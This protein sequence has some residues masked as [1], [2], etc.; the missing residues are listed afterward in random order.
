MVQNPPALEDKPMY[1]LEFSDLK[2]L[3]FRGNEERL[4]LGLVNLNSL[5][6]FYTIF[7]IK[8][9]NK[10]VIADYNFTAQVKING[11]Y[12]KIATISSIS[13]AEFKSVLEKITGFAGKE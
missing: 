12:F 2:E 9:H 6:Y 3:G 13:I 8:N 10:G 1:L 11:N 5:E 4:T 7:A